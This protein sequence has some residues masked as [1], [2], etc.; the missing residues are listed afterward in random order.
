MIDGVA[1]GNRNVIVD[2]RAATL[3]EH[4]RAPGRAC[5]Y[6]WLLLAEIPGQ[7]RGNGI[8]D[9]GTQKLIEQSF[10]SRLRAF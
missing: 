4:R 10:D 2:Q 6:Y 8:R 7:H 9:R 1:E 3:G 5:R